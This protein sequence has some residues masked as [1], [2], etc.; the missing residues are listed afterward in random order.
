MGE[1]GLDLSGSDRG[2]MGAVVYMVMNV[3]VM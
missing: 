3:Q 2:K 1:H